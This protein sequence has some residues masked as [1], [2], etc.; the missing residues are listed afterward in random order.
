MGREDQ[1]GMR[2]GSTSVRGVS[3]TAGGGTGRSKESIRGDEGGQHGSPTACL[4]KCLVQALSITTWKEME[5]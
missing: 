4:K 2:V 3:Q 1:K 5:L